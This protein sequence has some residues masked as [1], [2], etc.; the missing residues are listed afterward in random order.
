MCGKLDRPACPVLH[1]AR[2]KF[3]FFVVVVLLTRRFVYL[4]LLLL[5]SVCPCMSAS[6]TFCK[7]SHK[8]PHLFTICVTALSKHIG[9]QIILYTACAAK[10][11]TLKHHLQYCCAF[12]DLWKDLTLTNSFLSDIL[13]RAG[14]NKTCKFHCPT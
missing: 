12:K 14:L 5:F 11:E 1:H 10:F 6:F 8:Y 4:L 3:F 9:T 13:Y 7:F 2:M